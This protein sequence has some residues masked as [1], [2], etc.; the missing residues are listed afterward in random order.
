NPANSDANFFLRSD[1][2]GTAQFYNLVGQRLSNAYSLRAFEPLLF[3]A[4][5]LAPGL[6]I[7]RFTAQGKSVSQRLVIR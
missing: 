2:D 1:R 3:N 4:S 6:Y 5:D 7:V